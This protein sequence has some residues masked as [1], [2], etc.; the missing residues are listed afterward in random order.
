MK[1]PTHTDYQDS[2]QD[3][4]A[5]FSEPDLKAGAL[6]TDALGLPRV[7][8]GNFAS[9]YELTCPTGRNAIRCF[10]RQVPGQQA[11]YARLSQHLAT[12]SLNCLVRFD[13]VSKGILVHGEW[14]PIVRM[15]WVEGL[16]LNAYIEEHV[17][18]P[19]VLRLLALNWRTMVGQLRQNRIAHGDFQHGNV[20]VTAQG[21][22][23]L[24]DYDG[25]FC[26]AFGR[27]RSPELGH[28]NF[29]HPRRTPDFYEERLD[30]FAALVIYLS[31]LAIAAEPDLW[32]KFYSGDNL[33]F[34]S[35]D[36]RNTQQSEVFNR[37]KQ[38]P[39]SRVRELAAL[40]QQCC[41][42]AV[43]STPWLEDAALAAD[44]GKVAELTAAVAAHVDH[45]PMVPH[46]TLAAAGSRAAGE[47]ILHFEGEKAG[48]T[49]PTPQTR[50]S[51]PAA[52]PGSPPGSRS[53]QGTRPAPAPAPS[54]APAEEPSSGLSAVQMLALGLAAILVVAV[55]YAMVSKRKKDAPGSGGPSPQTSETTAVETPAATLPA[56]K[57]AAVPPRIAPAQTLKELRSFAGHASA[58]TWTGFTGD[59]KLALSGGED[60]TL[61]F[62]DPASGQMKKTLP[63]Q[64]DGVHAVHFL[65]GGQQAVVI[66]SDNTLRWWNFS[67]GAVVRTVTDYQKNLWNVS[68]SPDGQSVTSGAA[69]RKIAR[70]VDLQ[71]G[72][73]KR[74][75]SH[76]SWVRSADFSPNGLWLA[77]STW[78]EKV[79]LWALDT[80]KPGPVVT[81]LSNA[82]DG[83]RFSADARF[84]V[85]G[86]QG[87]SVRVWDAQNG[88]LRQTL[89]GLD[90]EARCYAF[91][92]NGKLVAAGSAD[93]TVRVWE[94]GSAQLKMTGAS[95]TGEVTAVAFS[96]DGQLLVTGSADKTVK[97]WDVSRF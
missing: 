24:V 29:Q 28:V 60:G 91:S 19:E 78:D 76:D 63:G 50:S 14:Y 33:L 12:V 45:T 2:I 46:S 86:G 81:V 53:A 23:R 92:P 10:V 42:S 49:R 83:V 13:Y 22:L 97:L 58:V 79:K 43:E 82:V 67:T 41:I 71:T 57:S 9:V 54:R 75:L 37:L 34:S 27:V 47:E 20:M 11:R 70:V 25:M 84:F 18:E 38:S 35:A 48:K 87:H 7:L 8:S 74:L 44:Q 59:G 15:Q 16:Q 1:W 64:G 4:A 85:S 77:V 62:W 61:L 3:P 94:V 52:Q 17:R 73:V 5:C 36:F 21:D 90:G 51:S 26:P 66:S 30:T 88:S 40:L 89:L 55:G 96:A 95:H 72:A 32:T 68:L 6:R 65:P 80:G 39:D 69:D 56:G 93:K 31:L